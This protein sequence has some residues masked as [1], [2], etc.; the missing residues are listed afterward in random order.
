MAKR[1]LFFILLLLTTCVTKSQPVHYS[2]HLSDDA[3]AALLTCGPGLDFYT[4]WGHTALRICDSN[5]ITTRLV[6]S[7]E[8]V[9]SDTVRGLDLVYNYGTFNFSTPHFYLKFARG[10]LDYC[11]SRSPYASFLTEYAFEGRWVSEQV[12]NL[13]NAEVNRLFQ[14]ME[15]NYLPENRYYKYDFFKDNCATR[16]RDQI[17]NAIGADDSLQVA[18]LPFLENYSDTNLS[19]RDIL[20]SY[21]N[22]TL[23]WWRF[24]LDLILGSRCDHPVS[25]LDYEFCPY[26]LQNLAT[27][28][29]IGYTDHQYDR[30]LTSEPSYILNQT[31]PL[32]KKSFPPLLV[33]GAVFFIFLLITLYGVLT[34]RRTKKWLDRILFALVGLISLLIIFLWFFSDHY[35]TK[36]NWN[37]LW[38]SP[39]FLVFAI[40]LRKSPRWLMFIQLL[41]LAAYLAVTLVLYIQAFNPSFLFIWATL[42]MRLI[43]LVAE[44]SHTKYRK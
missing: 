22:D 29:K 4:T 12:L 30:M 18:S 44:K 23:E 17:N 28:A 2:M 26:Y 7:N 6:M 35:C 14:L 13:T 11:L 32:L 39:L 1:G 10:R 24:G 37:I 43:V 27:Q 31:H 34:H 20:D 25:H 33:F 3:Y 19:F 41:A 15:E 16:V 9:F 21:L 42:T 8:G 5:A 40:A 36:M 38:A